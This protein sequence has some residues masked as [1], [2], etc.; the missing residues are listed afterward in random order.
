MKKVALKTYAKIVTLLMSFVGFLTGCNFI[1][2]DIAEYGV[3]SAD[4]IAKGKVVDKAT[5]QPIPYIRIIGKEDVGGF[6]PQTD[7]VFTKSDGT[8]TL[9]MNQIF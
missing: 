1:P 6:N 8:Y 2:N 9:E 4:F 3:P 5:N 7:T